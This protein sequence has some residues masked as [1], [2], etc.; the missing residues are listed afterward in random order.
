MKLRRRVLGIAPAS[1]VAAGCSRGTVALNQEIRPEG[2]RKPI[3]ANFV[4]VAAEKPAGP[5]GGGEAFAFPADRGGK[6]LGPLLLP[7]AQ[8]PAE[9]KAPPIARL[10]PAPASVAEPGLPLPASPS[11]L[12]RPR[13]NPT[14]P[15]VRPH[16]LPDGV[17]LTA[18]R[19]DPPPPVRQELPGGALVRLSS[20]DVNAPVPLPT[21]AQ[22]GVDRVTL[23]DP[24]TDESLK[25]ALAGLP[26]VRVTPAPFTPQRLP[27][28]TENAQAVRVR[29][30]P[31]EDVTPAG[32][33][34]RQ[35]K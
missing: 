6:L 24:T 13:L 4:S 3:G 9:P 27:D 30:L 10:L 25:A 23:E 2:E 15:P 16:V 19:N 32:G 33:V 11:I 22:P 31:P 20:R 17:P 26:T 21:L 35:P 1:C 34:P 18:Y 8:L 28:P 12:P 14:S 7:P 5:S 29:S